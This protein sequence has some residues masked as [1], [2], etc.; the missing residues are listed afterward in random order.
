M[1][2]ILVGEYHGANLRLGK[3]QKIKTNGQFTVRGFGPNP[4]LSAMGEALFCSGELCSPAP[5]RGISCIRA[6]HSPSLRRVKGRS[7]LR[8]FGGGA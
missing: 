7:P 1:G 6:L 4:F 3:G 8:G 2:V 5:T